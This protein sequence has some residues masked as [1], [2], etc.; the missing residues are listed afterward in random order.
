M[1]RLPRRSVTVT[2][3]HAVKLQ[4]VRVN[5]GIGRYLGCL[6][7]RRPKHSNRAFPPHPLHNCDVV[8]TLD[9]KERTFQT[10]GPNRNRAGPGWLVQLV[11][12]LDTLRLTQTPNG[13]TF[14]FCF[15]F[16][17][18]HTGSYRTTPSAR[19]ITCASLHLYKSSR[20]TRPLLYYFRT[21]TTRYR[22]AVKP[23]N[24]D[25]TLK[26][27]VPHSPYA[28]TTKAPGGDIRLRSPKNFWKENGK[29][30]KYKRVVQPHSGS[31]LLAAGALSL[32]C[33]T[34]KG[35]TV[36]SKHLFGHSAPEW[37]LSSINTSIFF[38]NSL[39][40]PATEST[41]TLK[42]RFQT[43]IHKVVKHQSRSRRL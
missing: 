7:Q 12:S 5:T 23:R 18:P 34:H 39:D 24:F 35:L 40:C 11:C 27:V 32:Y 3:K 8:R 22:N 21:S 25:S 16:I 14:H 15:I 10:K 13:F 30:V 2:T 17:A 33:V 20:F 38:V 29:L 43:W 28:K 19:R 41:S 9:S 6:R 36:M 1:S 4:T 26:D 37:T 31:T 42:R